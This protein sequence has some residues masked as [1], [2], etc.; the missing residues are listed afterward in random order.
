VN[1]FDGTKVQPTSPPVFWI[2]IAS[3]FFVILAAIGILFG[4]KKFKRRAT[5]KALPE[6]RESVFMPSAPRAETSEDK[7]V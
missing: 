2:T 5:L 3:I 4:V 1:A 6:L 7:Q